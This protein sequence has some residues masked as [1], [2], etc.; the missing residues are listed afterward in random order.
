ML[1]LFEFMHAFFTS[2][3]LI[4]VHLSLYIVTL[5]AVNLECSDYLCCFSHFFL[6]PRHVKHFFNSLFTMHF[7]LMDLILEQM[8]QSYPFY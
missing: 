8:N 6:N 7:A 4:N 2:Y 3:G 5:A 1:W